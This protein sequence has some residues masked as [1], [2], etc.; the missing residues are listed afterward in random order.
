MNIFE[1]SA[2]FGTMAVL[3]AIPSASV[4]LVVARSIT[5]GVS[6]G[7]VVGLGVVAGDLVFI[8]LAMF[9]LAAVAE[10]MG[11]MFVILKYLGALY[12]MWL[13]VSLLR[14]KPTATIELAQASRRGSFLASFFSG[15]FLTLGDVKAILFYLSLLPM[16]LDLAALRPH[17]VLV[18]IAVTV[19]A[20]GGIKSGYAVFAHRVMISAHGRRF[21]TFATK[22]AGTA[23]LGAGSYL[24]V[25]A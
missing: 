22:A 3:A 18:V 10:T 13:G 7:V 16:F 17:D 14:T 20:V 19:L 6:H 24:V 15:F 1:I 2:L 25:K 4:A 9:G 8:G 5:A 12:L 21:S 23:L 11:G